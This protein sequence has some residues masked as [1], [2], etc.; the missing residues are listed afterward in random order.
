MEWYW[1]LALVLTVFL[2][3]K[4]GLPR[5][6]HT[7]RISGKLLKA[8]FKIGRK[9]CATMGKDGFLM[10]ENGDSFSL[11]NEG[12]RDV[13]LIGVR[14]DNLPQPKAVRDPTSGELTIDIAD[15][16][17]K[18]VPCS[19]YRFF[20]ADYKILLN[21]KIVGTFRT[22]KSRTPLFTDFYVDLPER[23][24]VLITV[25]ASEAPD[26]EESLPTDET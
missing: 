13:G 6:L 12:K 20:Y 3:K 8:D 2:S 21:D 23:E 25:L 5:P 26:P 15:H 14:N 11:Y 19:H 10:F 22:T 7:V 16:K 24:M 4:Y 18:V 9:V 1:F 17:F